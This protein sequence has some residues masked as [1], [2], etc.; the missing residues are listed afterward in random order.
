MNSEEKLNTPEHYDNSKGTLYKVALE[1]GWNPYLTDLV[2]RMER[3]EK[4]GEFHSDCKKS[5]D[6]IKLYQQEQG[7]RFPDDK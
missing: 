4:K 1:R 5:I 6:V 7:H 2:K 3:V